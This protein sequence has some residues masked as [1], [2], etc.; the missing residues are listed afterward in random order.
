MRCLDS[1]TDSMDMHLK[2]LQRTVKEREAWHAAVHGVAKR[3][4]VAPERQVYNI[5]HITVG[6]LLHSKASN[7]NVKHIPKTLSQKH[8][9]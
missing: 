8:P 7:L 1:I 4:D 2:K 9:K 5:I 6:N 3:Y